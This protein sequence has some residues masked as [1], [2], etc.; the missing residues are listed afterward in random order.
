MKSATV[1]GQWMHTVLVCFFFMC[2]CYKGTLFCEWLT[3]A[4]Q[5]RMQQEPVISRPLLLPCEAGQYHHCYEWRRDCYA[6][7]QVQPAFVKR[8]SQTY[9]G[10]NEPFKTYSQAVLYMGQTKKWGWGLM[11]RGHRKRLMEK[12][13]MFK[14]GRARIRGEGLEANK[15]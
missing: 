15:K 3:G 10:H 14:G 9:S 6:N 4:D 1:P 11:L 5:P 13:H 12:D 2:I 8:Y 7:T